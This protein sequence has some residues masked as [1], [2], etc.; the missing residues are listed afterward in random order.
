MTKQTKT[1]NLLLVDDHEMFREGLA[2]TLE[3]EPDLRVVGQCGS[4]KEALA[5]LDQDVTMV[6]LDVDLGN[7]RAME[8]VKSAREASFGGQI[9]V[10]TAGISG[11]EAV[12]LIQAGVTG[13]LDKRHSGQIL[14]ESIRKVALGEACLDTKYLTSLVKSVDRTREPSPRLTDRDRAML[15]FILEGLSNREIGA[16]LEISEGA[17][18]AS[19]R[20][21]FEKTNVRTRAQ[22]VKVALEQYREQLSEVK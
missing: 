17:V 8:F 4:S 22:L 16:Q 21:L 15:R 9:L 18:K 6:L 10:V 3:R 7:E 13:I 11:Q 20:Q 1:I 5:K 12:L 19:L 14:C 2:R